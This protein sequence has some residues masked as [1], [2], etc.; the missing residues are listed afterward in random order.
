MYLKIS[1]TIGSVYLYAVYFCL[2]FVKYGVVDGGS[3]NERLLVVIGDCMANPS[4]VVF[5]V[6]D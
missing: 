4:M 2:K 6:Q 5:G 1:E 3:R